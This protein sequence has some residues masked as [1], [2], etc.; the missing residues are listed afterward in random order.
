MS[1]PD[2]VRNIDRR[3]THP[4]MLNAKCQLP[5]ANYQMPNANCKMPTAKCVL[6]AFLIADARAVDVVVVVASGLRCEHGNRQNCIRPCGKTD[7]S[8][9][10]NHSRRQ[11]ASER[12]GWQR[13][14]R[15]CCTVLWSVPAFGLAFVCSCLQPTVRHHDLPGRI[16]GCVCC[17]VVHGNGQVLSWLHVSSKYLFWSVSC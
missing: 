9:N 3:H 14:H 16:F 15:L 11:V 7:W 6:T 1:P 4:H 12:S 13:G 5:T 10:Q 17:N 8:E 2:H